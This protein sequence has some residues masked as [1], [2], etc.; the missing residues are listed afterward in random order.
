MTYQFIKEFENNYQTI[1]NE[2]L[3]IK[4]YVYPWPE[5]EF[6]E[7]GWDVFGLYLGPEYDY[8]AKQTV[9]Q[10]D[11]SS[12]PFTRKLIKYFTSETGFEK[13]NTLLPNNSS[14]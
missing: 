4:D 6:H 1:Y 5:L 14:S 10:L 12:C 7:G 9:A 11:T 13:S 8:I 2:Y 3:T